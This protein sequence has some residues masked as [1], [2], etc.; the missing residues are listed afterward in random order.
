MLQRIGKLLTTPTGISVM[1][2]VQ[3]T[4]NRSRHNFGV[5]VI[6]CGVFDEL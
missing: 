1:V 5:G 3:T 6:Q 4:F 2:S